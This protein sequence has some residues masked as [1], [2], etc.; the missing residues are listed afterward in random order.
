[1]PREAVQVRDATRADIEPL[2]ALWYD[3]WQ[4]AH[5]GVLPAA[6]KRLRTRQSFRERLTAMRPVV[7]V[8]GP[9]GTPAG[10]CIVRDDELYQ[11][12]VTA[13]ARGSG[14]AAALLADAEH[15]WQTP[16]SGPPGWHA[17]SA[18]TAPCGFMKK[19]DGVG[20]AR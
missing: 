11:L 1:M 2:A 13:G 14:V 10:F 3:G 4:D 7:R 5:A 15:G 18:M 9:V 20:S 16:A 6:L 17:P 19:A 12:Y 8:A